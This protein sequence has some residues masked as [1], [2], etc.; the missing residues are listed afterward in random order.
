MKYSLA[1]AALWLTVF[2]AI[3]VAPMVV[4]YLGPAPARTFWVEVAVGLGFVGFAMMALQFILTGRYHSIATRFGLDSMLQFHRQ[5]GLVAFYFIL[6]H[7]I[8]L[9]LA[10]PAYLAYLDPR[11]NWMR[12]LSLSAATVA[13]ILL[14]ATSLWRLTFR[15]SYEWWRLLHGVFA[16]GIM[17]VGVTH[18]L[19]VGYYVASFW[20]QAVFVAAAAGA[21]GLLLNTRLARPWR[22]RGRPYRVVEVLE[23]IHY[24]HDVAWSLALEPD[25]HPGMT[26][27]PGQ[28]AWITLQKTP[29]S[30]QQNPYSF[31]SSAED[32][33]GRIEFTVK[34]EGSFS[35]SV[36][37]AQPGW[38]AYL[39]GP[40]GYFVPDPDP[41]VGCVFIVG[42]V[43]VTP[44]MSM[45]R[46]F[47]DRDDRRDLHLIYANVARPEV[48]FWN[49]IERLEKILNLTVTHVLENP[50]A[51]WDGEEGLLDKEMIERL[52]PE[53]P[54]RYEYFICGP[55]PLMN[56][57]ERSL[58][59]LGIEQ[60]RVLSERFNMV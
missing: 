33:P 34:V 46:T 26:F 13:L 11:E 60:R 8:I 20:Q 48:I 9:F 50:P 7:P 42:G 41:D 14:I 25:G 37:E 56:I 44:A 32:A 49:E 43:G 52:L 47:A 30:M 6:A 22:M 35:E 53:H 51:G 54:N 24:E 15:L 39:E 59:E 3:C 28:F 4:A 31:A 5:I 12:A 17:V 57:A 1:R 36:G 23:E 10:D 2:L 16:F 38:R 45:L 40:Y 29:F 19:Q 18:I 58:L 27:R 55:E 21:V